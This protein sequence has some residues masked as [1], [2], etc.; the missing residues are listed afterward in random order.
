[1]VVDLGCGGGLFAA[2][3]AEAGA[4]VVGVDLGHC[5]LREC[6]AHA[7]SG[8]QAVVGDVQNAPIADGCADLVLLADVLEHVPSPQAAVA[9]AARLLR[10]GGALFVNTIAR[11]RRSRWLAIG[12]AEGLGYV[13]RGTHRWADFV[14]PT[15][16]DAMASAAGLVRE[17]RVGEQPMLL[18]TLRTGAIQLRES[19]SLAVG[20]AALYR[21]AG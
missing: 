11:T 5:A 16:L 18:R 6:R 15:E 1:V 7:G 3:L 2:P 8:L 14:Q 21:R 13:P 9:S 20:Y 10:P 17:Q 19:R 12:L 4:R